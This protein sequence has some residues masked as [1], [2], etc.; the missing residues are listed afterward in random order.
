MRK[1]VL[2][3]APMEYDTTSFYRCSGVLP[4]LSCDDYEMVNASLVSDWNWS[5]FIPYSIAFFHRPC[6]EDHVNMMMLAKDMGLKI[7]IDYDDNL[8]AVSQDNPTW[9]YYNDAK[10]QILR[11]MRLA[12]QV[13]VTTQGV[14]DAY[15]KFNKD[16]VVIPNCHNDFLFPVKDKLPFNPDTKHVLWRGGTT[17]EADIYSKADEIVKM[18]NDNKDWAF[19]FWG[20]AFTYLEQRCGNNYIRR[21]SVTTIQY[22]K[23]LFDYRPNIMMFPLVDNDFNRGKSNIA[24]IEGAYAGAAFFGNSNLT[25]FHKPGIADFEHLSVK[26][27]NPDFEVLKEANEASWNYIQD[28]LLL[29]KVNQLRHQNILNLL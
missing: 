22:F 28:V 14:K 19:N 1:K 12:D 4:Y 29:S 10:L 9:Q 24:W 6:N 2:F 21:N 5:S 27:E 26:L 25:E 16:T 17:H 13:W 23:H 11:C 15:A 3:F 8:F 7:I 20:H 18:V